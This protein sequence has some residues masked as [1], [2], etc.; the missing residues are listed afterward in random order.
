MP[1]PLFKCIFPVQAKNTCQYVFQ[2]AFWA[3]VPVRMEHP[4]LIYE[5]AVCLAGTFRKQTS[6]STIL[7]HKSRMF[8]SYHRPNFLKYVHHLFF[9]AHSETFHFLTSK[10]SIITSLHSLSDSLRILV[11]FKR[12]LNVHTKDNKAIRKFS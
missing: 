12:K 3:A 5:P 9:Y 8:A 1:A 4:G 11:L 10:I 6:Y 7:F 2:S